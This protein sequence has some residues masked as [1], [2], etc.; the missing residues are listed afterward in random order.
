MI[1]LENIFFDIQNIKYFYNLYEY[2]W[3][4]FFIET[5]FLIISFKNMLFFN[6]K[7][8]AFLDFLL[9]KVFVL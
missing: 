7:F 2:V 1:F 8:K 9:C 4:F 5:N 6:N 3:Q